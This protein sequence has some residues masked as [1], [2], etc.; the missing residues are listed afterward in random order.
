MTLKWDAKLKKKNLWFRIEEIGEF[1]PNHSK[2]WKFLFN[3]IFLFKVYNVWAT[4]I[5]RSYFSWHWTE[6]Q[7]WH[8]ELDELSLEH[9]QVWKFDGLFL[10]KAYN[11]S[12]RKFYRNYV[13]WHWRMMQNLKKKWL[14]VPKMT[15]E[16]W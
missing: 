3:G 13:S 8:E 4:K 16:T 1:S 5:Q 9:L 2:V 7:K 11:V 14:L 6:M 12:T 10:S 15:W